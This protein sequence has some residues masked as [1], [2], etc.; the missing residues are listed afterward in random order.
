MTR[1][2]GGCAAHSHVQSRSPLRAV[3]LS[4]PNKKFIYKLS[5]QARLTIWERQ[6]KKLCVSN[7]LVETVLRILQQPS[8]T[9]QA[10]PNRPTL[11]ERPRTSRFPEQHESV[12]SQNGVHRQYDLQPN[13]RGSR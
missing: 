3:R 10:P 4:F 9:S 5:I 8:L 1:S 6:I 2:L 12:V 13:N 7:S 11:G